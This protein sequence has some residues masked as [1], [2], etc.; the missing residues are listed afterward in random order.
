M[1]IK[2]AI[3]PSEHISKGEALSRELI[4]AMEAGEMCV[5]DQL[6]EVLI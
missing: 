2:I 1:K 3:I 4:T 5:V 6:T